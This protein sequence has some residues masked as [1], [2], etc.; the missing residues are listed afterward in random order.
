MLC[1]NKRLEGR[2][3]KNTLS[4]L[5]LAPGLLKEFYN[6]ALGRGGNFPNNEMSLLQTVG[7]D[8]DAREQRKRTKSKMLR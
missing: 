5:E 2:D 1:L 4:I 7:K 8:C 6:P 3:I